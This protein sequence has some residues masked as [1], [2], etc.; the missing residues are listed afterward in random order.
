MI[1]SFFL[2][3]IK[4]HILYHATKEP[5]YGVGIMKEIARHGYAV[6]P[7][8]IYPTLQSLE[9]QGLL[10]SS[11]RVVGGKVRKYYKTTEKGRE[12]LEESMTKIV[13]LVNEVLK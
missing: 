3:F 1:R 13:E 6:G 5:I 10:K 9:K 4:I 2:G 12:L 11:K 8:L 7:S